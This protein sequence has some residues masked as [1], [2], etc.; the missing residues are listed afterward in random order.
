MTDDERATIEH[1]DYG[2]ETL[3]DAQINEY[4]RATPADSRQIEITVVHGSPDYGVLDKLSESESLEPVRLRAK[5][6]DGMWNIKCSE[7]VKKGV[8]P[9]RLRV[10]LNFAREL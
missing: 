3:V 10:T 4:P 5:G 2:V 8:A 6:Y 9:R 1:P 7:E